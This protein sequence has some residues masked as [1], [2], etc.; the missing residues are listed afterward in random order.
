MCPG[1]MSSTSQKHRDFVGEPMGDKPVTALSG[2][3]EALGGSLMKKGFDKVGANVLNVTRY[4]R[5]DL[6]QVPVP[7]RGGEGLRGQRYKYPSAQ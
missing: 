1:R 6:T 4:G 7:V 3:G 2:I 5:L